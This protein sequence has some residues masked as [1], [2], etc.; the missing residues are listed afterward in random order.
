MPLEPINERVQSTKSSLIFLFIN[1]FPMSSPV[2]TI[3]FYSFRRFNYPLNSFFRLSYC[4]S[5][6]PLGYMWIASYQSNQFFFD[7]F[8]SDIFFDIFSDIFS[9]IGSNQNLRITFELGSP[10]ISEF[11]STNKRSLSRYSFNLYHGRLYC[12][13]ECLNPLRY[14]SVRIEMVRVF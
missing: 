3:A 7:G 1:Y 6:L 14:C 10:A 8:F 12:V 2:R 11:S 13:Y 9:D 5:H 4:S